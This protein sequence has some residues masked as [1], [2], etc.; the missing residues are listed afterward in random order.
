MQGLDSWIAG[1]HYHDTTIECTCP[2]GHVWHAPAYSEYGATWLHDEEG[3][4]VCPAPGCDSY[5]V[6][7]DIPDDTLPSTVDV[8]PT[9]GY[10]VQSDGSYVFPDPEPQIDEPTDAEIEAMVREEEA[11]VEGHL[12]GGL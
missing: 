11:L 6:D 3:G 5:D 2:N 1:G 10:V 8:K 4:I 9:E 12:S 7:S